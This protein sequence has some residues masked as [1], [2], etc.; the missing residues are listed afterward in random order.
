M[1]AMAT[2]QTPAQKEANFVL[3]KPSDMDM[4]DLRMQACDVF[5]KASEGGQLTRLLEDISGP[6]SKPQGTQEPLKEMNATRKQACEVLLQASLTGHLAD[7]IGGLT[8][9]AVATSQTSTLKEATSV[10]C[11][12]SDMDMAD[13]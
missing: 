5:T 13:L 4:A 10:P 11:K 2:P 6:K 12:P 3:C 9:K 1:G 8:A 7:V